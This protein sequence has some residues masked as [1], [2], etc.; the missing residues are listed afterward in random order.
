[1]PRH[2]KF[3]VN[4]FEAS[5]SMLSINP[6]RSAKECFVLISLRSASARKSTASAR[7][8]QPKTAARFSLVA[9]QRA[10]QSLATDIGYLEQHGI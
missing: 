6:E 7:E 8:W 9:E 3:H 5:V 10:E 1:M 4:Y 2:R